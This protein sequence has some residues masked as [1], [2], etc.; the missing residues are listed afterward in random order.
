MAT[1][2]AGIGRLHLDRQM[3]TWKLGRNST[4]K[5]TGRTFPDGLASG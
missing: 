3:L 4:A 2:E 1:R 5:K